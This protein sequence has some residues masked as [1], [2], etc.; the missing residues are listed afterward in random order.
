[1]TRSSV[2]SGLGCI[3]YLVRLVF[4]RILLAVVSFEARLK[5]FFTKIL[6]ANSCKSNFIFKEFLVRLLDQ[7]DSARKKKTK[8]ACACF[9]LV[10]FSIA[11]KLAF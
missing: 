5:C 4:N 8:T 9:L 11:L 2:V 10:L 6:Y 1:M 3:V 7:H